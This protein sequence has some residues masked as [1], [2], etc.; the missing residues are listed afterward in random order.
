MKCLPLT[1]RPSTSEAAAALAYSCVRACYAESVLTQYKPQ[2]CTFPKHTCTQHSTDNKGWTNNMHNTTLCI[3]TK[4]WWQ[5]WTSS[6]PNR[7]IRS[8]AE[9][10]E[11]QPQRWSSPCPN[12]YTRSAAERGWTS[13]QALPPTY[14]LNWQQKEEDWPQVNQGVFIADQCLD[15]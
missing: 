14:T 10:E 5:R 3:C 8:V 7:G 12:R 15:G 6:S 13:D 1:L 4:T 2:L 9:R 11:E